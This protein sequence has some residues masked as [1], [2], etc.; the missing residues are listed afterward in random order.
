M[1][2]LFPSGVEGNGAVEGQVVWGEGRGGQWKG[3]ALRPVLTAVP[4]W[5]A[6]GHWDSTQK[7][8]L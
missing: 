1:H 8:L 2:C 7:V 5:A 4:V 6:S 3:Q